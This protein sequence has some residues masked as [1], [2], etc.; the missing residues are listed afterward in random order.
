MNMELTRCSNVTSVEKRFTWN[1][2]KRSMR[3][4]ITLRLMSNPVVT[5]ATKNH[6]LTKQLV[7]SFS[8]TLLS[9]AETKTLKIF[10]AHSPTRM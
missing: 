4:I 6:A 8:M 10:F 2:D 1:G 3:G 5:S 9:F 7:A